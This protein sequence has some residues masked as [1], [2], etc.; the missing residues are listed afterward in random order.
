MKF[1]FEKDIDEFKNL[2]K[3]LMKTSFNIKIDNLKQ[4]LKNITLG[5]DSS[6]H[7]KD[8]W[9]D[10][11]AFN[12]AIQDIINIDTIIIDK[13][14][15]TG[16][17]VISGDYLR[18]IPNG[19]LEPNMSFQK[20]QL[21]IQKQTTQIDLKAYITKMDTQQKHIMETE[22]LNYDNILDIHIMEKTEQILVGIYQKENT[23]N[24]KLKKPEILDIIF[25]KLIYS[26]KLKIIKT[27]LEKLIHIAYQ[28]TQAQ[29]PSYQLSDNEKE[30]ES[31]I[32]K[33][34]VFMQDIFPDKTYDKKQLTSASSNYN[35]I[36][37]FIIQNGMK[38]ELFHLNSNK[39][40][41]KT[42]GNL[43]KIIENRKNEM[44]RTSYAKL[45]GFL[46]Y[47]KGNNLEPS[48]KITDIIAKGDKKSVRGITCI[49][50]ST[51]EIKKTLNK[52][53]SKVL[54]SVKH[55]LKPAFCNDIEILLKRN[56]AI[57]KDGKKWYYTPEE[58]YI[59]FES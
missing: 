16:K 58:Y 3:E 12:R 32:K 34:I 42:H 1:T 39:V 2:I 55:Q 47:E 10:E 51:S 57:N 40:F 13:F 24:I 43:N 46:K 44:N 50:K 52:L 45:Y 23:Y 53:D 59:Y 37:G 18:F 28:Q 31:V 30:V 4:Y 19:N 33:H 29:K 22:T 38:L 27:L 49:S 11:D 41:E 20:Q 6:M 14:G 26:Y 56:D 15:R 25:N 17:I 35:N 48:F 54:L 8:I 21:Q 36:Y 7:T 5:K 9:Q